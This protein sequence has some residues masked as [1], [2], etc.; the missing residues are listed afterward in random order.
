MTNT[1]EQPVPPR[2]R[3]L[4]P[5]AP[6]E[7]ALV[8]A[9]MRAT[10]VEVLG[11]ERGTSM[12]TLAWL[13]DRVRWHLDPQHCQGAVLLA[14][15][16]D[17]IVGHTIVRIEADGDHARP[18]GL[19]STIHV[20]P[21]ARRAHLA[22]A[23]VVEGEAWLLEH[24]PGRLATHTSTTNTPLIRLFEAH[25]YQIVLE[26]P[27]LEMV[28]LSRAVAPVPKEAQPRDPGA[29]EEGRSGRQDPR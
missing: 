15:Q 10:L 27:E 23:L 29:V 11:P 26:D 7:I 12:Y 21:P 1:H 25:G 19:F 28:Q 18:L 22:S 3:A 24:D 14:E 6:E 5:H 17:A 20:V 2:I 8:A 13:E 4:D 16:G 9:R